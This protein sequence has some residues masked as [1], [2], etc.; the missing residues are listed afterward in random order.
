MPRIPA[1][2]LLLLAVGCDAEPPAPA[3]AAPAAPAA[4]PHAKAANPHGSAT[5]PAAS[6]S[7]ASGE[8][9]ETMNSG[10]YSYARVKTASGELWAA[11]PETAVS[12]GDAVSFTLG[13][14][15]QNFH[16]NT[17]D[18]TFDVLYF[19][20]ALRRPGAAGAAAAPAAPAAAPAAPAG[21]PPEGATTVADVHAQAAAL[22]GKAVLV[23]G[24]VTKFNGGIMNR[25]WVHL[26]DGTGTGA[27]ADLTITTADTVAVGD[28]VQAQGVLAADKDFGAGYRF[29]VILEDASVNKR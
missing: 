6:G 21:P 25:N 16:S 17:L 22:N 12:V 9:L 3:P 1:T 13:M 29:D 26:S 24:K 14:P 11:G 19:V 10:G 15:M 2:L 20:D 8:V 5:A 27:T 28:E 4:N 7:M 23:A 18:R